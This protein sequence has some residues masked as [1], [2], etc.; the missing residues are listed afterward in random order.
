MGDREKDNEA[1]KNDPETEAQAEPAETD[2]AGSDDAAADEAEGESDSDK[3][4]DS[5][6]PDS[7]TSDSEAP[8]SEAAAGED[9]AESGAA[10]SEGDSAPPSGGEASP[11]VP[12]QT[13]EK[14][15]APASGTNPL[16]KFFW[17]PDQ[18]KAARA[19]GFDQSKPG[20]PYYELAR[21]AVVAAQR[22]GE[23]SEAK[24]GV[25]LLNREA[26]LLMARAGLARVGSEGDSWS[27]YA[28]LDAAKPM[29]EK[30]SEDERQLVDQILA[31]DGLDQLAK[32]PPDRRSTAG[33][34]LTKVASKLYEELEREA[35]RVSSVLYMRWFRILGVV[36]VILAIVGAIY[37]M[38]QRSVTGPNLAL[39]A[40]VSLSSNSKHYGVPPERAVDGNRNDLGF[41]TNN[42]KNAWVQLDL[43]SEKRIRKVVAYNRSTNPQRAV[44]LV[45][46]VSKDRRKWDEVAKREEEFAIWTADFSSKKVR[47]VRLRL[48][49][50]NFLH[51]NEVEVY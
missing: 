40:Q 28:Q 13:S 42:Q 29:V 5:E 49:G 20:W 47:Y 10:S 8:E 14:P 32:L 24:Q 51:L 9:S 48:L 16:V 19:Q 25:T 21:E 50:K 46:E 17:M 1:A 30:L 4:S 3:A 39:G 15:A 7:E 41:H 26:M 11:S 43:G 31:P 23:L 36:V 12:P 22:L 18:L 6:A 38:V 37:G 34:A 2:A 45:V 35:N 33:K 27:E 44:P